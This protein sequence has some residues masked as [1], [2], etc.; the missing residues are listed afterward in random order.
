MRAFGPARRSSSLGRGETGSLVVGLPRRY[1]SCFG[2]VRGVQLRAMPA[3]GLRAPQCQRRLERRAVL[4][5]D[6][7]LVCADPV[8][9][10]G[11]EEL[12]CGSV[13]QLDPSLCQVRQLG[14]SVSRWGERPSPADAAAVRVAGQVRCDRYVSP[15]VTD[16]PCLAVVRA[17]PY[18]V[19]PR[20][21]HRRPVPVVSACMHVPGHRAGL[22]ERRRPGGTG[23]ACSVVARSPPRS[24][25]KNSA[26]SMSSRRPSVAPGRTPGARIT[27]PYFFVRWRVSQRLSSCPPG[28]HWRSSVSPPPGRAGRVSGSRDSSLPG[29]DFTFW[30]GPR[31]GG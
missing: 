21:R 19:G 30:C 29:W 23:R 27:D 4:A 16:D 20:G 13:R 6:R 8:A 18:S 12:C 24:R 2:A 7:Q 5:D 17:H 14:K 26:S 15:V 1:V 11:P 3:S 10:V 31:V 9:R 22:F 28:W 25:P